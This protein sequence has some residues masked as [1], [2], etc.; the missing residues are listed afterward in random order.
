MGENKA[1]LLGGEVL[2]VLLP[3]RPD[4]ITRL[5][6]ITR[7]L[8]SSLVRTVLLGCLL[9]IVVAEPLG[10][11]LQGRGVVERMRVR[12]SAS[13]RAVWWRRRIWTTVRR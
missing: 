6:T 8:F 7:L 12:R 13:R 9:R 4:T 1:N 11:L 10:V 5:R 2:L 3:A